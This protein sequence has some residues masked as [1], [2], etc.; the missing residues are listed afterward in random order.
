MVCA[1]FSATEKLPLA[2]ALHADG[3]FEQP[4]TAANPS[5]AVP[6]AH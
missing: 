6:A 4:M 5:T 2:G 1:Y 3:L